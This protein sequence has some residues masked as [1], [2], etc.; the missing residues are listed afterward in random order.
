ML[1]CPL[2]LYTRD[3]GQCNRFRL[4]Q[5][6]QPHTD[7]LYEDNNY[8]ALMQQL[9]NSPMLLCVTQIHNHNRLNQYRNFDFMK[10][11]SWVIRG[12]NDKK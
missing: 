3:P 7:I 1:H 2:Y 9:K 12:N 8:K 4:I 10:L 11:K 6:H 5:N